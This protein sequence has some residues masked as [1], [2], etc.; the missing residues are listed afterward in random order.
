[1][2]DEKLFVELNDEGHKLIREYT[3]L[4]SARSK[5]KLFETEN[6]KDARETQ[7]RKERDEKWEE[8]DSIGAFDTEKKRDFILKLKKEIE[9]LKSTERKEELEQK[10]KDQTI[11]EKE[12]LELHA[13]ARLRDEYQKEG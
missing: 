10:L 13:V 7:L 11:T 4:K 1:M 6:E 8:F 3:K 12:L 2:M 5:P 9:V